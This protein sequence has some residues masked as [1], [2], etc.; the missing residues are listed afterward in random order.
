MD[1]A[2]LAITFEYA[3]EVRYLAGRGIEGM[4]SKATGAKRKPLHAAA[5]IAARRH[6]GLAEAEANSPPTDPAP[7]AIDPAFLTAVRAALA[8]AALG[9]LNTASLAIETRLF[10]LAVSGRADALPRVA[11]MLRAI[12]AKIR[13]RRSRAFAFDPDACIGL[14][15]EAD[16]LARALA[17]KNDPALRGVARQNYD[18]V[19]ALDL[20]GM[21]AEVWRSEAGARGVTGYFHDE[22]ADRWFTASVARAAG[23]DPAF[24]PALAYAHE[25]LWNAAP[26]ARLVQS[27]VLLNTA[28]A[29][30]GGRLSMAAGT[31]A[32]VVDAV[33]VPACGPARS[34]IGPRSAIICARASGGALVPPRQPPSR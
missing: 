3:P 15:A 24:D 7:A 23:Q 6:F 22:A 26:L 19:G 30:P 17:A 12:A 2:T 25:A 10:G 20:V 8:D 27:R 5:L 1:A 4:L 18:T 14:I 32:R 21:G 11:A 9:A 13:E 28:S 33:P 29:S 31:T 16:A 34:P